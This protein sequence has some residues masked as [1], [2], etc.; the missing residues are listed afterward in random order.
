MNDQSYMSRDVR[1]EDFRTGGR[2][3]IDEDLARA[4]GDGSMRDYG[5]KGFRG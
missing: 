3:T 5:I 2:P 1:G 4:R